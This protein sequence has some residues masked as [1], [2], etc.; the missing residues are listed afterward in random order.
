[1]QRE[2]FSDNAELVFNLLSIQKHAPWVHRIY[3]VT[4]GQPVD[5]SYLDPQFASSRIS[6]VYHEQFI[7]REY[8]PTFNSYVIE[9]FMYLIPNLEEK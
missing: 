5:T 1:M 6:V 7:P 9:A 3:I 2:R 8:L 4:A